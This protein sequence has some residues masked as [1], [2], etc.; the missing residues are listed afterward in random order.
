[1]FGIPE[2][3]SVLRRLA[4]ALGVAGLV[5]LLFLAYN[6]SQDAH[7]GE[8]LS[9]ATRITAEQV[10]LRIQAGTEAR[11]ERLRELASL[12][13]VRRGDRAAFEQAAA[14]I[15]SQ[16]PDFQAVNWVDRD[17]VI[18]SVVPLAGNEGALGRDLHKHPDPSVT[19]AINRAL[20]DGQIHRSQVIHLLQGGRGFAC[21]LAVRDGSGE[22]QGL[23]NGVFRTERLI[24]A[25]LPEESLRRQYN[26]SLYTDTRAVAYE[27]HRDRVLTRDVKPA[28]LPLSLVDPGWSFQMVP[29]KA[30]LKALSSPLDRLLPWIGALLSLLAGWLTW[31]LHKWRQEIRTGEQRYRELFQSSLDGVFILDRHNRLVDANGSALAVFGYTRGEVLGMPITRLSFNRERLKELQKVLVSEGSISKREVLFRRRDNQELRCLLSASLRLTPEGVFDGVMGFIS[32]IS[33]PTRIR[34][35]LRQAQKMEAIGHL[36]G[37]VAHDFNNL[38]TVISGNAELAMLQLGD[39]NP[40]RVELKEIRSTAGRAAN[41]TRQLLA[42]SRKQVIRPRLLN[43]NDTLHDMER[44]LKRIIGETIELRTD[45]HPEAWTVKVDPAQLEQVIVNLVVNARDAME[46]GGQLLVRTRNERVESAGPGHDLAP[47]E[48]LVIEVSDTGCGMPEEVVEHIFEPFYTTKPEGVGT[49][50]GLATVYGIVK[51]S[52]G[53]I[54]V[55]SRP[56]HGTLFRICLPRQ[57]GDALETRNTLPAALQRGTETL[58]VVEDEPAVRR[59]TVDSLKRQGYT[60]HEAGNG[61]IALDLVRRLGSDIDLVVSDVVM[62]EMGGVEFVSELRQFLPRMPVLFLSGYSEEAIRRQGEL[63]SDARLLQKPFDLHDLHSQVRE[64]LSQGA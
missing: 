19:L 10:V 52:G 64:L 26:L 56:G 17:Q 62:P 31:Y 2:F 18:R 39:D 24:D 11:L 44:M 16:Y 55:E 60:V 63:Q 25:C 30:H 42:F 36:A 22:L 34:E 37:G 57:A 3:G 15:L 46:R 51:Q 23:V 5:Q 33:E 27:C 40:A 4:L 41:L 35:Q 43:A 59:M 61:R 6:S 53:H 32:D 13:A 21:Y 29:T 12:P 45:L 14:G 38:L 58:L 48:Y 47:G 28:R 20:D 7:R 9:M 54:E 8:S 49:G 1:M 50:L